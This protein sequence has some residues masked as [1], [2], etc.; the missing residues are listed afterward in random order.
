L[1]RDSV[2]ALHYLRGVGWATIDRLVQLGWEGGL[3][4]DSMLSKL[5]ARA[6]HAIRKYWSAAWIDNVKRK[7][8]HH[9]IDTMT[10]YDADY[11][12]LL[13]ELPQAP[14]VLYL[15]GNRKLLATKCIAI[16]GTR[17]A[18]QY[19]RK[20]TEQLASEL[21]Q[22]GWTVVSGMAAGIDGI[23][24]Q[25]V[26]SINGKTI[27]VLGTGIDDVY[28]RQHRKLYE[29]LVAEGLVISEY[30]PGTPGHA[31]LF[32]QRNRIISGL[33]FGTVV[34]EA[35]ERSGSLITAEFSMEQGREV[36]AVPGS[37][38]S[39]TSKGTLSLIQQGAKCV[40]SVTDILEELPDWRT[41]PFVDKE[42]ESAATVELTSVEA[43]L[44]RYMNDEPQHIAILIERV[45]DR[46]PISDL[47]TSLLSLE[48]K[49]CI[50]QLPGA[51]Y[52]VK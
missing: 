1:L 27:A 7:L 50:K 11:P 19:G 5:P 18:S 37:I 29:Q 45:A 22:A 4:S 17:K 38:Y 41:E 25:R 39:P 35:A 6:A 30:A 20:V 48:I 43:E 52:L 40:Q 31:G 10:V 28:P 16:V 9:Q 42:K 23:A 49:G 51:Y 34:V 36:F 33:S 32:P 21:A 8:A 46:I 15:R 14:W 2:I 44:L 47:H 3:I 12:P 24:H 26:L 13:R